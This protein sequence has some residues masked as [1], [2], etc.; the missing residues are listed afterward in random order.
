MNRLTLVLFIILLLISKTA[1]SQVIE[2]WPAEHFPEHKVSDFYAK[3]KVR[4]D[5]PTLYDLA[6]VKNQKLEI[7]QILIVSS[8][9]EFERYLRDIEGEI[10]QK[11]L[12]ANFVVTKDFGENIL[13]LYVVSFKHAGILSFDIQLRLSKRSVHI[14]KNGDYSFSASPLIIWYNSQFGYLK[15]DQSHKIK[16]Y[17]FQAIDNL[18]EAINEND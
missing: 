4:F 16:D 7:G 2:G 10:I 18:I 13:S 12:D 8:N 11:F 14:K 5:E 15:I 1:Y 3:N 17:V 9:K 6:F